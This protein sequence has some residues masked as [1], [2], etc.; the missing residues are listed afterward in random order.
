MSGPSTPYAATNLNSQ[1]NGGKTPDIARMEPSSSNLLP[2]VL[3]ELLGWIPAIVFP[4][5]TLLQLAAI[6]RRRNAAGV[7]AAAWSMFGLA[8]ICLYAYTEKY[9]ELESILGSLGTAFLNLCIV[10]A[11]I[12]YQRG[13]Q[14]IGTASLEKPPS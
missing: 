4:A 5:A 12:R 3:F 14:A 8:N 11:A 10:V 9:S 7:S 2:P 6:V 13:S 1:S